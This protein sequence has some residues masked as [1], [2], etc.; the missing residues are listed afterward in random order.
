MAAASVEQQMG[1]ALRLSEA[2]CRPSC[3]PPVM[4]AVGRSYTLDGPRPWTIPASRASFPALSVERQKNNG[5]RT[6]HTL[7]TLRRTLN[8][9]GAEEK[10]LRGAIARLPPHCLT[11]TSHTCPLPVLNTTTLRKCRFSPIGR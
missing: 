11:H 8:T 5:K 1:T 2:A 6:Q 10:R 9:L 3:S 4:L 7:E